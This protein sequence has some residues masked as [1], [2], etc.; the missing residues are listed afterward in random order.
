[1]LKN[2]WVSVQEHSS[3]L[4][5]SHL[6]LSSEFS[7]KKTPF[8][9]S[10]QSSRYLEA[11]CFSTNLKLYNFFIQEVDVL[12][13]FL[14]LFEDD[15]L[16]LKLL[17]LFEELGFLSLVVFLKLKFHLL[18]GFLFLLNSETLELVAGVETLDQ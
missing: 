4:G 13:F 12:E 14:L 5:L 17:L 9:R 7:L 16:L 11:I 2:A 1:M 6:L 3:F 8:D 15:F 18:D 10:E